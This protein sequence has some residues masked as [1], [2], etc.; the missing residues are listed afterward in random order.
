MINVWLLKFDRI[1]VICLLVF[2]LTLISISSRECFISHDQ[3]RRVC[4]HSSCQIYPPFNAL[5]LFF[6]YFYLISMWLDGVVWWSVI[7]LWSQAEV[8]IEIKSSGV[9]VL[10]YVPLSK[11]VNPSGSH[12][13]LFFQLVNPTI[14]D[15]KGQSTSWWAFSSLNKKVILAGRIGP[16]ANSRWIN[17]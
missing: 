10:L 6:Y 15:N 9:T 8:T 12:E 2:Y 14:T 4:V 11:A 13:R 5:Y 7:W 1:L 3:G 16:I 17:I